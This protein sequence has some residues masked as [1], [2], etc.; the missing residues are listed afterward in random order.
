M[1]LA[2]QPDQAEGA[3]R[4]GASVSCGQRRAPLAKTIRPVSWME[5]AA[6]TQSSLPTGARWDAAG[7]ATPGSDKAER[8]TR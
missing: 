2:L 8:T 5:G 4:H 6:K 1:S 3:V 7:S